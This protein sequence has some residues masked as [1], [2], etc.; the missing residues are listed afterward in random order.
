MLA[1]MDRY[2]P[3]YKI[4]TAALGASPEPQKK[5]KANP[6]EDFLRFAGAVAP[7]AGTALGA[8]GGGI[9]GSAAGGVGAI[10]GAMVGGTI[11]GGIG[12][13]IGSTAN[14]GADWMGRGREEDEAMRIE[15]ER[16]RMARQQAA[17]SLMGGLR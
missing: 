7:V 12:A 15:R 3:S 4:N 2:N 1:R 14:M 6:L 11:G 13:G 10:P 9:L 5:A 16:E 17:L 8:I